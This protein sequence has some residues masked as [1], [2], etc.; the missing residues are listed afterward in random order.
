M[1]IKIARYQVR[2]ES[3]EAV[4]QAMREFAAHVAFELPDSTWTTYRDA[5]SPDRYVSV[6]TADDPG[7]DER[8][9]QSPGTKKFVDALYPNV[10]GEVEFT[11]Y[12]LVA[13]SEG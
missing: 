12:E 13:N 2:P 8:H 9:R 6:I 10:V 5:K 11:E 4:E 1:V 3:R 7:A